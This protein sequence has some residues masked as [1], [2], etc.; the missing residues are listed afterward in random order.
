[1]ETLMKNCTLVLMTSA[2]LASLLACGGGHKNP[3]PPSRT[4]AYTDPAPG[5]GFRFVKNAALSTSTHLVLDLV[6]SDQATASNGL[7]FDV[8]LV[9]ASGLLAWAKVATSDAAY[10]RNGAVFDVGGAPAGIAATVASARLKAVVGQKGVGSPKN[11]NSGVLASV[12]L[13]AAS[14]SATG[15][16]SFS[17]GK[18]QIVPGSRTITTVPNSSVSFGTVTV[19]AG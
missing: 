19:A 8:S 14:G 6:A 2:A 5:G 9:S 10:V 11:L 17:V 1:M 15:T 7:A 4:I 13:D 12:A 18:F 16:A 3:D